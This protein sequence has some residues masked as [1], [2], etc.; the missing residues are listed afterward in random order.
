MADR[1]A[2]EIE[3]LTESRSSETEI[4]RVLASPAH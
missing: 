2:D 4:D 1:V 3:F